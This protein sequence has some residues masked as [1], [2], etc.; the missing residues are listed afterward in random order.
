MANSDGQVKY[1]LKTDC[2]QLLEIEKRSFHEPWD[3][4]RLHD[5]ML[6]LNHFGLVVK[7]GKVIDGYVLYKYRKGLVEVV[8]IAVE[9][10][11]RR[12]GIGYLLLMSI[13]NDLTQRKSRIVLDVAES[14]LEAH[15][16]LRACGFTGSVGDHDCYRFEYNLKAGVLR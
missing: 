15:L 14:N 10:E 9:H 3:E 1:L 6:G 8:N 5:F 7:R 11:K 2:P 12:Q 16:F 4:S 13:K